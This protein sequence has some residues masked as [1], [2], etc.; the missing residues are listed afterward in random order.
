MVKNF[1]PI[2]GWLLVKPGIER[3]ERMTLKKKFII[4]LLSTVIIL[5]ILGTLIISREMKN[6]KQTYTDRIALNQM[7]ES[8]YKIDTAA[9]SAL[10]IA[11]IFSQL[12]DVL[13]AYEIAHSGNIENEND[14]SCQEARAFL[15][16]AL[17]PYM[18]GFKANMEGN[19]L[20][21]HFHLPSNRS[22]LRLW[23][24]K[25]IERDGKRVDISDDLSGF[26]NTVIDVNRT[27]KP[28]K[29]I[30]IGT[31]GF[32]IRGIAP[33]KS[34]I[35]KQMGSVEFMMDMVEV[36]N[37]REDAKT[38]DM[39]LYMNAEFLPIAQQ[40][41][42]S[43][44]YPMAGNSFVRV[45]GFSDMAYDKI[46]T[47]D[48]LDEGREGLTAKTTGNLCLAAFPVLDYQNRPIGVMVHGF[49]LTRENSLIRTVGIILTCLLAAIMVVIILVGSIIL[50]QS[51]L[52]PINQ[53]TDISYKISEGDLT[54]ELPVWKNDE[55]GVL[56]SAIN[57][58]IK[59]VKALF[60]EISNGV[61][62]L[63]EAVNQISSTS[64]Q[65]AAGASET[66]GSIAEISATMEQFRQTAQL[67]N[68]NAE[69][70]AK[71]SDEV[72]H[73]SQS[74]TT[75]VRNTISVMN[76]IKDE[77]KYVADS[78]L[79]LSE[80][81]R[82][83][84]EIINVVTDLADQSNLLSVNAAI[85]AS[86]AGEHGK[87]FVV[88]AKEIKSLAGQS[89]EAAG[90]IRKILSEI[91]SATSVA[92]MATEKGTR[93]V[94]EGNLL[95]AQAGETIDVL[96]G[97][98]RKT[99]DAYSHIACSSQ[100]QLTGIDQLSDAMISIKEASLQN[101]DG[102]RMLEDAAENLK[103]LSGR[104]KSMAGRFRT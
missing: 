14:I 58:M 42:D 38:K 54:R 3:T 30:E 45:A 6:L 53:L 24:D 2:L 18:D 83:I 99:V 1:C 28:L 66:S 95:S 70:V 91:Q 15:R 87:G 73:I 92:V 43:Q 22:F 97:N 39:A 48:L 77:M 52:R 55:I 59:S 60:S 86:K 68:E 4:P 29:G 16:N 8:F 69:K 12:T 103:D 80:Q 23:K 36:L 101:V 72:T 26:R 35:G 10:A 67:S 21:L 51:V 7:S 63:S 41:Q 75:A 76:R 94:D 65:L 33:I 100:E 98:I 9:R 89:K 85:E 37:I 49:D 47:P 50:S 27:G 57:D 56:F 46:L 5:G 104:L 32:V 25:Q 34:T 31:G 71:E 64:S 88:V 96:A 40:L 78:I 17:R 44:K 93:V 82:S 20:K 84:G 79:K 102:A 13:G 74:G 81:S 11:S 90:Q 61:E 62:T 19:P